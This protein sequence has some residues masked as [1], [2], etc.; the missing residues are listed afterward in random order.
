[1]VVAAEPDTGPRP[2]ITC[3]LGVLFYRQRVW[4]LRAAFWGY[5]GPESEG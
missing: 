5:V 2:L 3:V 1:M 4:G